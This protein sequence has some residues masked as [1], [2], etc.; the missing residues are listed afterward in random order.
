MSD[1]RNR[2]IVSSPFSRWRAVR[3]WL[4]RL[5]SS[6]PRRACG[7]WPRV[8]LLASSLPCPPPSSSSSATRRWRGWACGLSWS[9]PDTGEKQGAA[10]DTHTHA[11]ALTRLTFSVLAFLTLPFWYF[12]SWQMCELRSTNGI[13]GSGPLSIVCA[14]FFVKD[15]TKLQESV[16]ELPKPP[17]N[18]AYQAHMGEFCNIISWVRPRLYVK[19]ARFINEI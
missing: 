11:H 10:Q 18:G 1:W 9:T 8:S 19:Q 4:K 5:S 3:Q 13:F 16:Y 2:L 6:L 12:N 7:A 17:R 14:V 15:Y